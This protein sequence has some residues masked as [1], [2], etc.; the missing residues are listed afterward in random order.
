MRG[1]I[2]GRE[3]LIRGV[4]Q[5]VLFASA[6]FLVSR[7]VGNFSDRQSVV[8]VGA[9]CLAYLIWT[10]LKNFFAYTY[11]F[12]PFFV[13]IQ[14][15]WDALL[16]DFGV[17]K[18]D[19]E[20]RQLWE[21]MRCPEEDSGEAGLNSEYNILRDGIMF[22]FLSWNKWSPFETALIYCNSRR[23]FLT[24]IDFR[25]PIEEIK[26]T[27]EF[28]TL[29]SPTFYIKSVAAGYELG[30]WIPWQEKDVPVAILPYEEFGLYHLE[31]SDSLW[32]RLFLSRWVVRDCELEEKITRERE[33]LRAEHGWKGKDSPVEES[34]E[35]KYFAVEHGRI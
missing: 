2:L 4:V 29:G 31:E 25:E 3:L 8:L 21:R 5:L 16:F 12:Y 22:T 14:P 19:E 34:I 30:L 28:G 6:L 27:S 15:N 35:H 1:H 11:R 7:Y 18:D 33:K 17:V 26:I 13:H 23:D 32:D 10:P 24:K 20:Y 9:A